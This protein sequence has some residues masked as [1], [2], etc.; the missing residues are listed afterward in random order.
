MIQKN[1]CRIN[2]KKKKNQ[3]TEQTPEKRVKWDN[4]RAAGEVEMQPLA[5]YI[6]K[7]I[8]MGDCRTIPEAKASLEPEDGKT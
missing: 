7:G 1:I 8:G 4:Q 6:Y 2:E 5:L 3:K